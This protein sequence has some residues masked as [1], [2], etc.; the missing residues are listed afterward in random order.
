MLRALFGLP[1]TWVRVR[2]GICLASLDNA[3]LLRFALRQ[4]RWGLLGSMASFPLYLIGGT[5]WGLGAEY[6]YLAL[7]VPGALLST[8]A[9]MIGLYSRAMISSAM[10]DRNTMPNAT[11]GLVR[12]LLPARE[13][14]WAL[15]LQDGDGKHVW[16]T[17][18]PADLD[19]IRGALERRR[20]GMT[21]EV[22][23]TITYYPRTKVIE[24]VDG[25]TVA[26]H[27]KERVVAGR[28]APAPSAG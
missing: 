18:R 17:G 1:M 2:L 7:W 5:A 27:A 4:R 6:L 9:L 13:G 28:L 15:L 20:S 19:R 3:E 14:G 26:E 23:L 21:L 11:Q 12:M 25:M 10:Y 16:F 24:R 8:A 22:R